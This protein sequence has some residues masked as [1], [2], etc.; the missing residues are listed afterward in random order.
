MSDQV[1]KIKELQRKHEEFL[2][3][4]KERGY[5]VNN[6][7]SLS[8]Q[9]R[10]EF[11]MVIRNA[12]RTGKFDWSI[13]DVKY[14]EEPVIFTQIVLAASAVVPIYLAGYFLV[15]TDGILRFFIP[16]VVLVC[17]GHMFYGFKW[18][19]YVVALASLIPVYAQ[20]LMLDGLQATIKYFVFFV[21]IAITINS[22][23]LLKSKSVSQ[24]FIWQRGCLS[25]SKLHKLR[26]LRLTVA[27]LFIGAITADVARLVFE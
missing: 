10:D 22:Y 11:D 12:K 1:E 21:L 17:L 16:A 27:V 23:L 7:P 13:R 19:K 8:E 25:D 4:M 5:D 6:L 18:A 14:A 20:L 26:L 24:F 2:T 15:E 3:K 9:E